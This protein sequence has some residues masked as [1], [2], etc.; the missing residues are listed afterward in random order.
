MQVAIRI[1]NLGLGVVVTAMVVRTL[2]DSQYGQW[3]TV[4]IVLMLIGYFANFGTE[5]VVV[6]E[7]AREP[8]RESEWIGSALM[9]RFVMLGPVVVMSAV[10][11]VL[12]HESSEM[13][14]AGLILLVTMPFSALGSLQPAFRVRVNNT[15]PMLVLTFNSVLWGSAV[16][17]IYLTSGGMIA[18]AIGMTVATA[19]STGVQAV[20]A[21]RVMDR[22]PELSLRHLRVLLLTAVPIGL[23]GLL[24][25]AYAR[26]DQ[27]IVFAM[28]GSKAAGL[29]GS[30]Y[31]VLEQAH[32]IPF[33]ILTTLAPIIAASWPADRARM[34][35]AARMTAELMAIA[36][37]GGLAFAIVASSSVVRLVFGSEFVGAAS[38][39]PILSAAFVFICLGYLNG[40]LLVVLGLQN[41]MLAVSMVA[42]VVNVVGNLLLVPAIGF[43]GAAWM[44]L[45]TE[46]VVS[47]GSLILI[48]RR[49]ELSTPPAGRIGRTVVAAVALLGCL[50]LLSHAG[51]SLAILVTVAIVVY[52]A[53]LFAT[54]SI[55][56]TDV[57]IVL[58]RG[59]GV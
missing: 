49:L 25:I 59:S 48:M 34:L 45:A 57:R 5:T 46:I 6:R 22:P 13:L 58:R 15:V 51:A 12:I 8:E 55:G 41:R 7:V 56:V 28:A 40:N 44:T 4:F 35:R 39:L 11:L 42:L 20:A 29:Y 33:S 1:L 16:A 31:N 19:I 32:F 36:S 3:S 38:A 24:V 50:E 47:V 26:V 17:V 27:V 18:L 43:M 54:R 14:A 2:G 53:L 10:A 9:L 21:L 30:V 23:S 52:P 37:L